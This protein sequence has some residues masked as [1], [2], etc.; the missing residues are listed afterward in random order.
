MLL[1]HRL[2][3]SKGEGAVANTLSDGGRKRVDMP[4]Q[5]K[6]LIA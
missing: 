3:G 6:N 2:E 4:C 1:L 5:N